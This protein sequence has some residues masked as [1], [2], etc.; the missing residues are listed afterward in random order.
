MAVSP[1]EG[2]FEFSGFRGLRNSVDPV[3]FEPGDLEVAL[4]VDIDDGEKVAR[5]KGYSTVVVAGVDRDL[6]AAGPICLG[7]GANVLKQ[8]MPN[9][10][11][12]VL[13]SGL[14]PSRPLRYAPL[15]DRIYYSNGVEHGVVQS[16]VSRSWGLTPPVLGAATVHGGGLRAGQY[17]WTMTY[18]R[19]DGQESGAPLAQVVEVAAGGGFTITL[20][21]PADPGVTHKA[22]YLSHTDGKTMY[23]YATLDAA[24]TTLDVVAERPG[25]V[26]LQTQ[27]LVSPNELG[28][29][30]HIAYGNGRMLVAAGNKLYV[31][32]PYAPELFDP[33]KVYA[34]PD[35][36]TL[37]AFLEDGA[38]LGTDT[39]VAWLPSADVDQWDFR[40]R[41]DYGAIPGTSVLGSSEAIT[42]GQSK[43]PAVFF[44]T[45]EGLC[46]G[47]AGGQ[48]VNFTRGRFAYPKQPAG[49]G[50]V[51]N[52]R[53]TIQ[54]LTTLRGL[55]TAANVAS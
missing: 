2:L 33:R 25:E 55:E 49:A 42:E 32:E 28:V 46:A 36:I 22:V 9:F 23:L 48:L 13:R 16:G 7:V 12:I 11:T 21:V 51:R 5:R 43:L 1:D 20:P 31:S 24:V 52:Y 54:Y 10:S 53:G 6:F 38:W 30:S 14:T 29:I 34:F 50:V 44:A 15:A 17:Q 35:R 26:P 39:Q 18:L 19:G 27:F 45:S 37:V 8:I 41:A 4:N 40:P 3:D 47:L